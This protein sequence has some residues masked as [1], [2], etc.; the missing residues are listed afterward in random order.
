MPHPRFMRV[1]V[2]TFR[3]LTFRVLTFGVD[4]A[5]LSALSMIPIMR[6]P[7]RRSYGR[8]DLHFITFSCYR[9]LPLLGTARTRNAFVRVLDQVRRKYE[10]A[11]LGY[12]VMPE[13]VH[14][15]ISEPQK[16][17]PSRILQVLKQRVSRTLRAKRRESHA[18]QL[19]L[20]FAAASD[21]A[22]AFWQRRFYDFNVW[23]S[24]KLYEKLQYMHRNPLERKLVSHPRQWPWS[25]WSHY[26]TRGAGLIRI[27]PL[28]RAEGTKQ[29]Q[30][31]H[32]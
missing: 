4:F 8:G 27:D 10:F 15:L 7:L 16:G 13:H 31:P 2:L 14:L 26:A 23:S 9:R 25:S 6:N 3:V 18:K 24:K 20:P 17:D 5:C 30:N 32:P 19:A 1:R 29:S 12:V 28:R 21:G 22:G 11:L